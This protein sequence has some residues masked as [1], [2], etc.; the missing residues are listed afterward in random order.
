MDEETAVNEYN[1]SG[2]TGGGGEEAKEQAPAEAPADD[3]NAEGE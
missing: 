2:D 1:T 3:Q